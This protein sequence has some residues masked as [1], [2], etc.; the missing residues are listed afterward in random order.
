MRRVKMR[1]EGEYA[2]R[3]QAISDCA[4]QSGFLDMECIL[5]LGARM[6]AL[7]R[8]VRDGLAVGLIAYASVALFYSVFDIL[9]ARGFLYT[10]DLL[11]RAMFKGLRD[12]SL[13]MFSIERDPTAI[14]LYNAFHLVMSVGIGLVVT[15]LVEQAE[16]HPS[17]ALL[18]AV[19]IVAG[20]VVTVFGV[21]YLTESMRAV[22]PWWSI[23][24][25]NLLAVLLAGSYLVRR[26]PG[27][28]QR[29]S[30]PPVVQRS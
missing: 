28:L 11:G 20:G 9:A 21:A 8:T 23:V 10:V 6:A 16:R 2:S 4:V 26:R 14:L 19:M 17:Q 25:A 30:A 1:A 7:N 15:S 18:V 22:L 12:P 27:L 13:L 29:I 24:V 5:L 3:R